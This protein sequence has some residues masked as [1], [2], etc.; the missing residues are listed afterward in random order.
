MGNRHAGAVGRVSASEALE[1]SVLERLPADFRAA[2]DFHGH[3][4]PGLTMGYRAAV[5]A[6]AWLGAQGAVDEELVGIV[7]TDACGVDAFQF[8]TGC[9]LGKGNL[10]FKDYGKQAFSLVRRSD[11]QGVRVAVRR[12]AVER[13]PSQTELRVRVMDGTA[14]A[15][16]RDA[17]RS[18]HIETALRLLETPAERFARVSEARVEIPL[19]ARLFDSVTCTVCGEAVMEPRS[20]VRDGEPC[21]IPCATRYSRGWEIDG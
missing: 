16:E 6:L 2:I 12:D 13:D 21:C 9:T 4:C 5:T 10:V 1:P 18:S 17:F 15:R 8:I 20:R 14:T 3:L 11:G 7:E 19:K